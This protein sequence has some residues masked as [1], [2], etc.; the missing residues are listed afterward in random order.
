M[1]RRVVITGMGIISPIGNTLEEAWD[2]AKNGRPGIGPITKYDATDRKAV[3]AGE[4]KNLDTEKYLDQ[5]EARKMDNFTVYAMCA[6]A[7]AYADSGLEKSEEERDRW[8]VILS[9]GIGGIQTIEEEH[10]RGLAKGFDKVSP[11]YIP[12][13]ISNMAAGNIA[14]KYGLHG[15]C[16]CAVT[17]CASAANGIGDAFRYIRDGYGDVMF[18]GGSEASVTPL[19]MGG[20]S[21]LK[22]LSKS[23]DPA[24]ASIPFDKERNGFVMG[25]GAAVLILEEYEHAVKRGAHI[26]AEIGGYGVTCDAYHM[27]AL[28]PEVTQS[29]RCIKEA[30][31][32]AG[33]A[34]EDVDYVNA[35]GT[36]TKMNDECET[37]AIKKAF[38]EHAYKLKISSTKSMT[39]HLLG[40]SAA[41]EAVLT[42]KAIEEG[43]VPPTAGLQVPDEE[44][45][46]DY[47]PGKGK[48]ADI[49]CAISNSFGF[50][51]HNATLLFKKV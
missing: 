50:G 26:Y 16:T 36:S 25:E 3:L 13:A 4:I 29:S 37:K 34:P 35:H 24:R 41:V 46:L 42:A 15:M 47:T 48:E 9:S 40:A 6:A 10:D 14:I 22:A 30:I 38:G 28:N 39:G 7:Q 20:F 27:T 49:R 51:G 21:A 17:A 31:E 32:D 12:K 18:A 45:D 19:C 11:Y 5:S 33:L 44:C 1:K 23:D 8:G 43:F 2:N